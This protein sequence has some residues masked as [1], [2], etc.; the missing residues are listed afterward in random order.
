[1]PVRIVLSQAQSSDKIVAPD[2]IEGLKPD[3]DLIADRG[4]DSRAI[5]ELVEGRGGRAHIPTCHNR[6]VQRSV[7]RAVRSRRAVAQ[8]LDPFFAERILS[9]LYLKRANSLRSIDG[10][11]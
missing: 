3:R 4:Y 6:K 7:G 1:M 10:Y 5:I 9:S 2:L 8:P 11:V